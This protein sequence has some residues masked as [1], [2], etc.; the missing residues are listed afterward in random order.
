[1]RTPSLR[2][3]SLRLLRI[4]YDGRGLSNGDDLC[5]DR[6]AYLV[7]SVYVVPKDLSLESALSA[8][9]T[10]AKATET[11]LGVTYKPRTCSLEHFMRI[12]ITISSSFVDVAGSREW[13]DCL[14][15]AK[16]VGKLEAIRACSCLLDAG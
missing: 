7:R 6:G 1:M 4:S 10:L 13:K 9:D 15:N 5:L 3:L 12:A 2:G 16:S 14:T 11:L 8:L